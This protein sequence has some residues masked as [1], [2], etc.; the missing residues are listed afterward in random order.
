[1]IKL[2]EQN[3]IIFWLIL[4]FLFAITVQQFPFYKGNSL[5][6]LHAIKNFGFNKLQNDWIANTTNHLPLFTI[7]N[8]FL[9]KFFSLKIL[10]LIHFCLLS[11]CSLFLFLI[12]KTQFKELKNPFLSL[13]WFSLFIIIY[14]EN[15]LFG[16]VAGQDVIN[17]GY[18]PAS[19]GVLFFVGIYLFL[20]N[21]NFLSI[22]FICL[23]ASFHPTYV[24]HS[25]FLLLGICLYYIFKKEYAQTFKLS[26]IYIILILPITLYILLNFF[27]IDKNL[28]L[29][30]QKILL[31]RAV[32]H[33]VIQSWFS[34]KDLLSIMVYIISLIIVFKEK[35]FFIPFL[36]LG[37]ISIIFSFIQF[38]LENN[39]L[40]LSFPWRSSVFLVPISTMIILSFFMQNFFAKKKYIKAFSIILIFFSVSTFSVKNHFIENS[41]KNFYKKMELINKIKENYVNIDRLLIPVSLEDVRMNIGL[42]IFV[43]WKHPPFKFNEI[44]EWKRRMN[45]TTSFF[46]TENFDQKIVILNEIDKIENISHLLINKKDLINNCKDLIDDT[47]YSLISKEDCYQ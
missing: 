34:Y 19:F 1:M 7:F 35:K 41:N 39:S 4:S 33:A 6:L 18:Q 2:I 20:I 26:I 38:F 16:G 28:I 27:F 46:S 21:K 29:E 15:S 17:E 30:G 44:I 3:R 11:L 22:L 40:A 10:H 31:D 14:H 25:G 45:L 32:H 13:V 24:L 36:V 37:F 9:I 8:H 42:P 5:H 47:K 43:D 23:A 12:C